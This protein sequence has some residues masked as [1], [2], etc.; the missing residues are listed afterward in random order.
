MFGDSPVD[1]TILPIRKMV[2]LTLYFKGMIEA[3][4]C[5][6]ITVKASHLECAIVLMHIC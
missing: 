5:D 6:L 3:N 2:N 1:G 4:H